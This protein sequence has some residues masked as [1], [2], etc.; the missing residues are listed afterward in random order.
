MNATPDVSILSLSEV[1]ADNAR[2]R[3]DASFFSRLAIETH[4]RI[5][6]LPHARLGQICGVFR[7]GIFDIK[8]DTYT[9]SG[10]PFVRI[11]NLGDGLLD[12]RGMAHISNEAHRAAASTALRFGDF[13]LSKTA[14]ASAALVT[15][16]ECNVSQDIIA[17]RLSDPTGREFRSGFVV[18]YLTSRYGRAL[19]QRQFQGNVQEHLALEDGKSLLVPTLGPL[20]QETVHATMLAAHEAREVTASRLARADLAVAAAMGLDHW[21]PPATLS[22]SHSISMV[23][24]GNRLDAEYHHPARRI[25]LELL[26]AKPGKP[27]GQHYLNVR[28]IFNPARAATGARVRNFDLADALEPVLD[29]EKALVDAAGVGSLKKR[30]ERGDVVTSRLRAYLRETALVQTSDAVPNVGSTEFLVLRKEVDSP[31]SEAALLAVLRS[32][33]V[34]T[35]LRWSQDGSHHPRYSENDLLA[36]PVPDAVCV[37][38]DAISAHVKDALDARARALS[39]LKAARRAVEIAIEESESAALAWLG[40]GG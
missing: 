29:D 17:A 31:L 22:Y 10:V 27:L 28:E 7:K 33:P 2:A 32:A 11:G 1:Q 19:M 14:Y 6:A 35:I 8:A 39:L 3:L 12:P 34:Q 4:R 21:D 5:E 18:A 15:V 23:R 26:G 16:P 30:F 20:F 9:D 36:I 13:V 24:A 40:S 25:C 37:A 38:S